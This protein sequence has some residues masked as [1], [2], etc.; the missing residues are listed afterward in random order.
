M[1]FPGLPRPACVV[2]E[3]KELSQTRSTPR[4]LLIQ[5][6]K[7][8]CDMAAHEQECVR[9]R[10]GNRP[11]DLVFQN[12]LRSPASPGW[13]EGVDAVIIGGSGAFSVHDERSDRWVLPLRRVFDALLKK[14]LPTF[15]ICFGHQLLGLHLGGEVVTD[16]SLAEVGTC[17]Y[18]LTDAG[19]KDPVFSSLGDSFSGHTGHSD[20]VVSP[21][22]SLILLATSEHLQTQAFR[23]QGTRFYS[24]QFHPDMIGA[25]AGSRY[26]AYQLGLKECAPEVFPGPQTCFEVGRDD[27]EPLLGRFLD[28]VL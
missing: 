20:S 4:V 8:G 15:A 12:V 23:V 18:Q 24:T 16:S 6:R 25:E 9:G 5:I 17:D 7:P 26:H 11:I 14:D 27:T 3:V 13:L 22:D 19:R 28:V 2:E 10:L 1:S 21:P